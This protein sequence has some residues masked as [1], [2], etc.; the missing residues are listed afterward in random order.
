[1][2]FGWGKIATFVGGAL[3]GSVGVKLLTSKDAKKV[4]TH[5]TAAVLRAKDSV[6]E[7]VTQVQEN[8]EDILADAK[9][10]NEAR[11]A[12]EAQYVGEDKEEVIG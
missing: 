4:Y 11:A 5:A 12:E 7:T 9:S 10:I 2:I 1:M 3:F 6:M 8:C